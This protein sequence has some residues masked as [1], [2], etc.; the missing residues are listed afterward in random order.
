M[1]YAYRLTPSVF[2]VVIV[3]GTLCL[4]S[5][6]C[7][8]SSTDSSASGSATGTGGA[9]KAGA[10]ATAPTPP[11]EVLAQNAASGKAQQDAGKEA[12]QKMAQWLKDH[13]GGK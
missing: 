5:A 13:P 9:G 10:P 11:P 3:A 6:G 1:K 7:P 8:S 4:A 2:F 12:G